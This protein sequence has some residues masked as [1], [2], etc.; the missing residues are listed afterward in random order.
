MC[1]PS[2]QTQSLSPSGNPPDLWLCLRFNQLSLEALRDGDRGVDFV[3]QQH[4]LVCVDP[5]ARL[6]GLYPGMSVNQALM[7]A[8]GSAGQERDPR[9][10]QQQLQA[11]A[12]W[13]WRYTPQVSLGVQSVLLEVGHCLKLFRGFRRLYQQIEQDLLGFAVSVMPGVAH[14]PA[15]AWVLSYAVNNGL[16]AAQGNAIEPDVFLLLLGQASIDSLAIDP[17]IIRQLQSCGFENLEELLVAPREEIGERFG[18]PLMDYLARLLGEKDD[19]QPSILP[20][21]PFLLAQ[22]FAEPIHNSQW[23]EHCTDDMLRQLCEFLRQRQWFCQLLVWRFY[24]DKTLIERL[25]IPLSSKHYGFETFKQLTD[26]HI[27]KLRLGGELMRIELFSD[28]L[29][30]AQL[31]IDDFFDPRIKEQEASELVDKLATRLGDES[32][33][34]LA[35][36]AEPVP[37]LSVLRM[38]FSPPE[39][40]AANLSINT[41]TPQQFRPLWLF[42]EPKALHSHRDNAT[43]PLDHRR[44]PM[45]L[46]QGPDRIDSHWW[47][48]SSPVSMTDP[49]IGS[50]HRD[51]YIARQQNGR[52]LWVF[53]ERRLKQWFLHGL[54]G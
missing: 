20:P 11:L 7:V 34:Q 23:I 3:Y 27:E 36:N 47:V 19:P 46:I 15:A 12:H 25:S 10:E 45:Q 22:D 38:R 9:R 13:A 49:V 29:L 48:K 16:Q 37:E 43:Q 53:Y 42:P 30:P 44:R 17:A 35:C 51:Y 50:K 52:L 8:P 26:L 14:T 39:K 21:T 24:N 31:F 2:S 18:A 4:R 40:T 54:F 5:S 33:Y 1:P 28:R 41:D 6:Q 32:V